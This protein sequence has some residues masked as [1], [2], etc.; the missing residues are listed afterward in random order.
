MSLW[1]EVKKKIDHAAASARAKR[2]WDKRGRKLNPKTPRTGPRRHESQ[3]MF[4]LRRDGFFPHESVSFTAAQEK[5]GRTMAATL[6]RMDIP[7]KLVGRDKGFQLWIGSKH[8]GTSESEYEFIHRLAGNPPEKLNAQDEAEIG[9]LQAT[10]R[11]LSDGQ[12]PK[13]VKNWLYQKPK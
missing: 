5:A 10:Y 9:M 8:P 2:G 12:D 6:T 7:A 3:Q 11:I 1:E 13:D 4:E